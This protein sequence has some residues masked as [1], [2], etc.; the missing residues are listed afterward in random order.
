MVRPKVAKVFCSS[1]DMPVAVSAVVQPNGQSTSKMTDALM[2]AAAPYRVETNVATIATAQDVTALTQSVRDLQ[3]EIVAARGS[4]NTLDSQLRNDIN[5][6]I[7]ASD[8]K[9]GGSL[10]QA[11][12]DMRNQMAADTKN[13]QNE[14][15]QHAARLAQIGAISDKLAAVEKA[16][17]EA[18]AVLDTPE[19][20]LARL[21]QGFAIFFPQNDA[22]IIDR[23][24]LTTKLDQLADF[25]KSTGLNIRI[26][27][28]ADET[29]TAVVNRNIGLK[30]AVVVAAEL[31]KRGVD[32]SH[33]ATVTRST[34]EPI[35]D[36]A[37]AANRRVTFEPTYVGEPTQ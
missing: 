23:P 12:T 31:T 22:T 5:A 3:D 27:S 33:I 24:G 37:V 30:R 14:I 35:R 26:V 7:Q 2:A 36:G 32:S 10:T 17:E 19:A 34:L 29:G 11:I 9:L 8:T 4:L 20:K 15:D 25:L 18:N 1:A 13:L 21:V 28:H 16:T 6:G